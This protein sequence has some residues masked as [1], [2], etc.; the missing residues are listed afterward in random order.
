MAPKTGGAEATWLVWCF[1]HCLKPEQAVVRKELAALATRFGCK[2]VWHKKSMSFLRWLEGRKGSILLVADWREAKPITEEISKQNRGH[3]LRL[4]VVAQTA[5]I[6]RRASFWARAQNG[7]AEIMVTPGF[8]R[9]K[10]EE[11]IAS[12]VQVVQAKRIA[13]PA[14]RTCAE[15][16]VRSTDE[17]L[18]LSSLL[19]AVNDPMRALGLEKL[20]RQT[21]WQLYED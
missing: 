12:Y 3:D 1:E 11:L 7:C 2:L 4:C 5:T 19:E 17:W 16:T 21:M 13:E 9:H 14:M 10:V 20:I 6:L 15:I 18:S 8:L